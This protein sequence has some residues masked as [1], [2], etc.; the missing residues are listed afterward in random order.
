MK[1]PIRRSYGCVGDRGL[2]ITLDVY[3]HGMPH[4]DRAAAVR[5]AGLILDG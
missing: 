4:D 5:V 1:V 3:S 2:S